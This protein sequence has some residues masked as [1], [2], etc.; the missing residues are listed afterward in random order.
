MKKNE[1]QQWMMDALLRLM[2]KKPYKEIKI[3]EIVKEAGLARCTFYRHF[4]DKEQVL[5]RC[6]E[7][8]VG[9]L[10]DRISQDFDN[11]LYKTALAYFGFWVKH[12]AFFEILNNS[13]MLYFFLQ[14]YDDLMFSIS[15]EIKPEHAGTQGTDFSPKI[16]YH[17][18]FGMEGL[19][20]MAYRWMLNGCK[21]TPEELAQYLV[22]Y[23]VETYEGEPDC[24][25]Y[26]QHQTYPYDPCF[27]KPGHEI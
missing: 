5:L 3:M 22:A 13:K 7:S 14:N 11:T 21:E 6:C 19:W 4:S 25:Y 12:R 9:Q 10:R 18:F 1:A 17:F 20:G 16:R 26:D 27:I 23:I 24:Q 15:K 8:V 2:E